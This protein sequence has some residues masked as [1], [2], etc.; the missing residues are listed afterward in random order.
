[1]NK[2]SKNPLLFFDWIMC[3]VFGLM[4]LLGVILLFWA[5]ERQ[6]L[7]ACIFGLSL[8]SLLYSPLV[9]KNQIIRIPLTIVTF[10]MIVH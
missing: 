4:S 2:L 1:M 5:S 7:M 10:F 3:V 6:F 9:K 8:M